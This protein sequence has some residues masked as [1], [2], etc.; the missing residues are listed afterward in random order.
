MRVT[1]GPLAKTGLETHLG[2]ELPAAINAAL[3]YYVGRLR[4]GQRPPPFPKFASTQGKQRNG[5]EEA[6]PAG[7]STTDPRVEIEVPVDE[8]IEAVLIAD[9]EAQGVS[10]AEIAGHAV[11]VYLAELDLVGEPDGDPGGPDVTMAV[12]TA[13]VDPTRQ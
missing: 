1:L 11:L 8:R 9:A 2:P 5:T 6:E 13:D 3:V 7:R 10:A 12:P 4:T